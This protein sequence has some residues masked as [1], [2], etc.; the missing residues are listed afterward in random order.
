MMKD[1]TL[2]CPDCGRTYQPPAVQCTV[3]GAALYDQT[4]AKRVGT[5]L[6][7]YE[8]SK[9]LGVGG[10]GVVYAAQHAILEKPVAIKV[11]S[12]R[13]A[14]REGGVEQ[15]LREAK[16]ATRIRHPNIVDVTDFGTAPDGSVYF[17]MEYLEG[18]TLEDVLARDGTVNLFNA[19]NIIRQCCHAL[20]AAHE[21]G[22]VHRDLKP[23][24]IFLINREGRRRVVRRIHD[25][26]QERYVV[27]KE[28][29]FD[30]VKLFDFGVAKYTAEDVGPSVSTRAGMLFGTPQYMSPEQ[31]RGEDVDG[32]SDVYALGIVFYEMVAGIVPFD[33]DAAL[34]ILNGHVSGTV[35]PPSQRNPL[36]TVD[37]GTNRTILSCL[38]KEPAARYQTML[39]LLGALAN[40]F[41]D[42]V[43]LRDAHLMPGAVEAGITAPSAPPRQGSITDELSE[44]FKGGGGEKLEQLVGFPEGDIIEEVGH[45]E[46]PDA[47]EG[48]EHKTN[49][50]IGSVKKASTPEDPPPQERTQG[51]M[52]Y[53]VVCPP[54]EGP[55]GEEAPRQRKITSSLANRR[56]KR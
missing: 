53:G 2:T 40:C 29:R 36:V 51:T 47:D 27:E 3:D 42:Q 31:A 4:A 39:E 15:F 50:G 24:N 20:S 22:I 49:P 5:T 37:E 48:K 11:L 30:F 28:G 56:R 14:S 38:E 44:L 43:F 45:Q 17:V 25:D 54:P 41:T 13:F 8:V 6:G 21:E 7:S 52:T 55:P 23:E 26:S 33:G 32:R 16:A 19:V 34:D 35:V 9:I 1:N 12:D 46:P 10:M 18:I